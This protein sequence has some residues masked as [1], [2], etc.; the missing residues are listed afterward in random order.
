MMQ[1]FVLRRKK[2]K[3]LRDLSSKSE[4]VEWCD[5]TPEQS[6]IYKEVWEK[7][8][9][10]VQESENSAKGTSKSGR[11]QTG[12]PTSS[13]VLMD[14]RKAANHPLLFRTLY[15]D[16]KIAAMAKDYVKNPDFAD[17]PLQH[18]REDF[19]INSD[20][21]LSMTANSYV[22]RDAVRPSCDMLLTITLVLWTVHPQA[23]P[24]G[25]SMAQ[26]RQD[27]S[28]AA[29]AP[30]DKGARRPGAYLLS[31][32]DCARYLDHSVGCDGRL[33]GRLYRCDQS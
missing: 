31:I 12:K 23:R 18:V 25:R 19:K 2:D 33:M 27:P 16:A 30:E 32:H 15:D 24:T 6:K 1:P 26:G 14:L 5:M 28:S 20:A 13:N 22:V 11:P 29:A 3:V 7:T 4:I 21:Q 9:A 10:A 17:E 8:K